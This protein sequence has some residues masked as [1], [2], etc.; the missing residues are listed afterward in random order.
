M[1]RPGRR[2]R[3]RHFAWPV[4]PDDDVLLGLTHPVGVQHAGADFYDAD[5]HPTSDLKHLA[6][7]PAHERQPF[8]RLRQPKLLAGRSAEPDRIAGQHRQPDGDAARIGRGTSAG[9]RL[10]GESNPAA[11]PALRAAAGKASRAGIERHTSALRA[12]RVRH[13]RTGI[14]SR[15]GQAVDPDLPMS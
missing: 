2:A 9:R 13:A 15:R 6:V 5:K 14:E 3:G 8:L 7:V 10:A 12:A 1:L 11:T 4:L